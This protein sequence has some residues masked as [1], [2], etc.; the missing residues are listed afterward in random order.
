[1]SLLDINNQL[2]KEATEDMKPSY[3]VTQDDVQELQSILDINQTIFN[4]FKGTNSAKDFFK[5]FPDIK[6]VIGSQK[7][8]DVFYALKLGYALNGIPGKLVYAI[9]TVF[10]SQENKYPNLA[11]WKLQSELKPYVGKNIVTDE[12][13]Y[14]LKDVIENIYGKSI[15]LISDIQY[16]VTNDDCNEVYIAGTDRIALIPNDLG[17]A[18]SDD[19]CRNLEYEPKLGIVLNSTPI[20]RL[21][22]RL[23]VTLDDYDLREVL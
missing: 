3:V 7:S 20:R 10:Q 9:S 22:G 19:N 18:L 23:G 21:N 2:L 1:M 11:I 12:G 14:T 15:N 8:S 5:S 4:I 17:G 13:K 16:K 6:T